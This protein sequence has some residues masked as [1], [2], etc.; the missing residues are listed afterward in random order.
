VKRTVLALA[1]LALP[2]NAHAAIEAVPTFHSVGLSWSGSGGGGASIVRYRVQGTTDWKV[3]YPLW[4]DARAVGGRPAGEYRGSLVG[5]KPG[6][7]YEIELSLDGKPAKESVTVSTWSETFPVGKTTT[8]MD[9]AATLRITESGSKTAYNVYTGPATIDVANKAPNNIY[10]DASFVIIRGLTLKGASTNAIELGPNAHDVVIESNDIS[11]WGTPA[12]DGWGQDHAAVMCN[13]KKTVERIVVQ[14]NKL[15]HPR[16]DANNWEEPR[17][18]RGGDAHPWGPQGVIFET[19]GGNHVFRYNEIYSDADHYFNDGFGG[20]DN[21]SYDGFP[22][23]DSDIYGN[24]ISHCWDDGIESEGGNRNVRIWGNYIDQ[25]FVKIAVAG[26]SIGPVYV[27][28]N[29][30]NV[31]RR[32][33]LATAAQVDGEDRGPFLKM[34]A[35]DAAYRAGR[36][37]VFHNTILQPRDSKYVNPLGCGAGL[38]DSG[39]DVSQVFSRNNILHI[40]KPSWRSVGDDSRSTT[41]SYDFDLYNGQIVAAAGQEAKGIKGTPTYAADGFTLAAG[42]PGFDVGEKLPGFNDDFVGA[43][44]ELGAYESGGKGLEF[45][46]TAGMTAPPSDGGVVTDTGVAP[47]AMGTDTSATDDAATPIENQPSVT[48]SQSG[49]GCRTAPGP[50]GSGALLLVLAIAHRRRDARGGLRKTARS[51][52]RRL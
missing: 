28:R 9:S 49:C 30:S 5:L 18:A 24:K 33:H 36:I 44:P 22:R 27:F 10:V 6:T 47:D 15:H 4:F 14:R 31:S 52:E 35:G 12:S 2:V 42:S 20:G 23:N 32:S 37:F 40:W 17:P 7:A 11:G 25:T 21:F 19:C 39:G 51:G 1:I 16:T 8:V 46:I 26:T 50:N 45:G 34:G 3:S 13:N 41:S 29:V 38:E 43:G 48:E